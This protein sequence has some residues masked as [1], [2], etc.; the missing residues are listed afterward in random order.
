[1]GQIVKI[2]CAS[3]KSEWQCKTGCGILHGD[4]ARVAQIYPPKQC[5]EIASYAE[6][7][8]YPLFSFGYRLCVCPHCG[9]IGSVPVL[10][11]EEEEKTYVGACEQCMKE[12]GLIESLGTTECPVC[13][14]RELTEEQTGMWD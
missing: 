10:C 5:Q 14:Q 3:C 13:R 7:T 9:H 11:L 2:T 12:V 6:Q 8:E 4:L 1:M